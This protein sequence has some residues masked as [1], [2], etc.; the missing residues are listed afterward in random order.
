[1]GGGGRVAVYAQDYLGFNVRAIHALGGLA[2]V[3]H[4]DGSAGTVH[5]VQGLPHTHVRLHTPIGNPIN[6][7]G[8]GDGLINQSI[9]SFTLSFNKPI[10]LTS[11]TPSAFEIT[12][13]MG[14]IAPTGMTMIGDRTYRI[15]LPFALTENGPYHFRLLPTLKDVE[16]FQ[17]D[18]NA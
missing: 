2:I 17:L 16:G 5:V 12:G 13:Q 7:I 6:F 18:Q 9:T 15:D 3:S 11:F 8:K 1:G 10:D 14:R 4:D